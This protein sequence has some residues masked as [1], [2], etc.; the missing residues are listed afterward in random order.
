MVRMLIISPSIIAIVKINALIE[1][2]GKNNLEIITEI[3][4][5]ANFSASETL[6]PKSTFS[7]F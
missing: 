3:F 5:T 2:G 6:I 7:I 4:L 1:R